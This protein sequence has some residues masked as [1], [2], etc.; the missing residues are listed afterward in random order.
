VRVPERATQG[1][2]TVLVAWHVHKG[3]LDHAKLDGL[4]VALAVTRGTWR[5][6]VERGPVHRREGIV[7]LG[8]VAD[9]DLRRPGWRAPGRA[10]VV[11]GQAL[12]REES[13]RSSS[14]R[15]ARASP[16]PTLSTRANEASPQTDEVH[17][18]ERV[19]PRAPVR[20]RRGALSDKTR[21]SA[22]VV[23]GSHALPRL[24][25]LGQ[26]EDAIHWV[27]EA[28]TAGIDGTDR[29]PVER[30]PDG[31]AASGQD[32]ADIGCPA[33]PGPS[34]DRGREDHAGA[35]W[36]VDGVVGK[37]NVA[38]RTLEVEGI[39]LEI[40]SKSVVLVDCKEARLR[41]VP[42]GTLA[43]AVYKEQHG[44]NVV[45]VLEAAGEKH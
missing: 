19:H 45:L 37:L 16:T 11:R 36:R 23:C 24:A 7:R 22:E 25:H 43:T 21:E 3:G 40:N 29:A 31:C 2:C 42:G 13:A 4:N 33:K 1:E 15:A 5:R 14:P 39:E 26:E 10:G 28:G 32:E 38:R 6:P 41:D 44:R 9:Q 8:A 30:R 12:G 17:G 27:Q 35:E 34:S 18:D 20:R